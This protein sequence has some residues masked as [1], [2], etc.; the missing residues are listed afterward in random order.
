MPLNLFLYSFH[1]LTHTLFEFEKEFK[2]KNFT[3]KYRV[4]NFLKHSWRSVIQKDRYPRMLF[5][6][7]VRTTLA[8]FLG[9]CCSTFLFAFSSTTPNVIAVI[10][11]FQIGASIASAALRAHKLT[12]MI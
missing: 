9:V 2:V 11:Q 6:Y 12:L 4:K 5:V 8:V 7:A 10:A 1:A 3:T